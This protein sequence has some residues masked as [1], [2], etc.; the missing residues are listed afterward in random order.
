MRYLFALASEVN[1][2][3]SMPR[4]GPDARRDWDEVQL[5]TSKSNDMNLFPRAAWPGLSFYAPD[6]LISLESRFDRAAP[7]TEEQ[8]NLREEA[9]RF[10][11][12][13]RAFAASAL[14]T[15]RQS[16]LERLA[17]LQKIKRD[18]EHRSLIKACR[19]LLEVDLTATEM[20]RLDHLQQQFR[21]PTTE[22]TEALEVLEKS[23]RF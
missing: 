2:I 5:T 8:R 12:E 19:Q 10:V 22:L 21:P 1:L 6:K 13:F 18:A 14:V 3:A 11:E 9:Q 15:R 20:A 17:E 4:V 23:R 16:D 7:G